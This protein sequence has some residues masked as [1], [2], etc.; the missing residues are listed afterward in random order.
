MKNPV[1]RIALL[2]AVLAGGFIL[3]DLTLDR[4]IGGPPGL[5]L[6]HLIL[7]AIVVLSSFVLLSRAL[8][9]RNRAEATLRQARDEL[10]IRVHERTAE[11]ARANEALQAEIAERKQAEQALQESEETL[12]VLMNASP[13]SAMLCDTQGRILA[14]N[15]TAAQRVG[16]TV[17]RMM[18]SSVFDSFSWQVAD[19]RRAYLDQVCAQASPLSLKMS[20]TGGYSTSMLIRCAMQTAKRSRSPCL[21]TM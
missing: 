21:A 14:A 13:E 10:E 2:Y 11:L 9:A 19:R 16:V 4:L 7:A 18:G 17:D 15:E 20:E 12:R 6:P 5:G 8:E 3:L 1:F